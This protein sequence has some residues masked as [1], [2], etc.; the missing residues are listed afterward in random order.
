[1]AWGIPSRRL[2][3]SRRNKPLETNGRI[4]RL[5][6]GATSRVVLV[7]MGSL[8]GT[9]VTRRAAV[10]GVIRRVVLVG[11]AMRVR[12][13]VALAAMAARVQVTGVIRRV[14]EIVRAMAT[15]KT[16]ALVQAAR[17]ATRKTETVRPTATPRP[18]RHRRLLLRELTPQRIPRPTRLRRSSQRLHSTSRH[19]Y[20]L[21]RIALVLSTAI[22]TPQPAL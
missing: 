22:N 21:P 13:M 12:A 15:S 6:T 20:P 1:M 5:A 3:R 14:A 9:G 10:M 19:Q 11:M 8:R 2:L 17:A 4:E 7:V 16:A 18:R